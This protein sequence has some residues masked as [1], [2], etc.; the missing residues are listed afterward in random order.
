MYGIFVKRAGSFFAVT[1]DNGMVAPS[2]SNFTV[3]FTDLRGM[4]SSSAMIDTNSLFID[5]VRV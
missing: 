5:Y 2:S 4:L 1:A 3:A